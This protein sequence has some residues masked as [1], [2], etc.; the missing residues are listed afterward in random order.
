[1]V[2]ASKAAGRVSGHSS[3]RP[4]S[5][6]KVLAL[7]DPFD[8]GY[9]CGKCCECSTGTNVRNKL[10]HA[11]KQ[12]CTTKII[13]I[14][15]ELNQLV[16]R[17]KG[18]VGYSMKTSPPAPLMS[19]DQPN[20]PSRFPLGRAVGEG[21]LKRDLEGRMQR[22]LLRIPDCIV[23]KVTGHELAAMRADVRIDWTALIPVQANID[24]VVEIKF[25]GDQLGKNQRT[26]YE[27]IAGQKSRFRLLEAKD[28]ECGGSHR[29]PQPPESLERSPVVTPILS[30]LE[31][32]WWPRLIDPRPA[33]IP[34]PQTVLPQY[35]PAAD[36][37]IGTPLSESLKTAAMVA[38]IIIIGIVAVEMIP[39]TAAG[40][41]LARLVLLGA[42]AV[43][44]AHA[45]S[46]AKVKQP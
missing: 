14:D 5:D 21:L 19:K 37:G 23:L 16:W 4:Q 29:R 20:R 13:W 46:P 25:E 6:G 11:L 39:V 2:E 45:A 44:A 8:K 15:E 42:G 38:G 40:I 33:S 30:P 28:C 10:G 24:T 12:R 18:E 35:G 26:A 43:R 41:G 36:N 27:R 9:L 22:G 34:A 17:Y 1:M 32:G 7:D 31:R 3:T